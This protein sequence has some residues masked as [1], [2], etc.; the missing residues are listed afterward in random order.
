MRFM[1]LRQS[2]FFYKPF[3]MEC[4][5]WMLAAVAVLTTDPRLFAKVVPMEQTFEE[6]EYFGAFRFMF[7]HFGE[8]K[9]VV[10]DDRLPTLNGELIFMQSAQ[11]DEFWSALLEKAYAKSPSD[12]PRMC[13]CYQALEGGSALEA[14]IDFTG[15][16]G[17]R[18]DLSRTSSKLFSQLNSALLRQSLMS[19]AIINFGGKKRLVGSSGPYSNKREIS[20]RFELR[21]GSYS[22]IVSTYEPNIPGEF[23]VRIFS[24]TET[25][26]VEEQVDQV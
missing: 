20:Q 5:C 3:F 11:K 15:G 16:V 6:S 4:D 18:F 25:T 19:C 9:Q 10:V 1:F 17:E 12:H 8:F 23:L 13:G 7:W 24:E 26:E 14:L 2:V 22:L 21:A